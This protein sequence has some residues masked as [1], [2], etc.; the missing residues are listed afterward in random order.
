MIKKIKQFFKYLRN[1]CSEKCCGPVECGF[2]RTVLPEE[3]IEF[4][5]KQSSPE[6]I[7]TPFVETQVKKRK[8]RKKKAKIETK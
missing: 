2:T 5:V 6:E 7:S 4:K 3:P 8:P 1:S